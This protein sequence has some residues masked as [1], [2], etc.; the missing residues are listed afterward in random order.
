MQG[1]KDMA[2]AKVSGTAGVGLSDNK[3]PR[4]QR[5]KSAALEF[6]SNQ[7]DKYNNRRVAKKPKKE[8]KRLQ[9]VAA[10]F[11]KYNKKASA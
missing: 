10:M 8:S 5:T 11:D 9:Q 1:S 3:L 7:F 6:V 4:A 2:L